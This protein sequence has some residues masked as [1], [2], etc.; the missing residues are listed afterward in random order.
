MNAYANTNKCRICKSTKSPCSKNILRNEQDTFDS[1]KAYVCSYIETYIYLA[2][3][4]NDIKDLVPD[5]K[6]VYHMRLIKVLEVNI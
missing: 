1:E 5:K 6:R 3:D 2:Y 4:C